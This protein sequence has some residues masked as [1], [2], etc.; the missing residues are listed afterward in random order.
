MEIIWIILG[1]LGVI[2]LILALLNWKKISKAHQS[3]VIYHKSLTK[4][5]DREL[6][7]QETALLQWLLSSSNQAIEPY[8]RQIPFVRVVGSCR[9]GCATIDLKLKQK[10]M[11]GDVT[12]GSIVAEA[13]GYSPSGYPVEV[14]LHQNEGE[15]SELE[16]VWFDGPASNWIPQP[17][18]LTLR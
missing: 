12:I 18:D 9:C 10:T 2:F 15:L 5:E 17:T 16:V 7:T 1:V 11:H 4:P 3:E 6:T 14:I 8:R 13:N